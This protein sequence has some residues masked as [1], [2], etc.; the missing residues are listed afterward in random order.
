MN[1]CVIVKSQPSCAKPLDH[2]IIFYAFLGLWV[3]VLTQLLPFLRRDSSVLAWIQTSEDWA[4]AIA[5]SSLL[6]IWWH[7]DNHEIAKS[8][9]AESEQLQLLEREQLAR[10]TSVAALEALRQSEERFRQ[11]AENINQVFWMTTPDMTQKL[12]VSPAYE[13]IWGKSCTS[14][15]EQPSSWMD[16]I[17]PEDRERVLTTIKTQ[18]CAEIDQEFRI[19]H[20]DGSVR[21]IRDRAFPVRDELG[22]VYRI[23]GIGED[24]TDR[25]QVEEEVCK[26]LEKE[27]ELSIL[28]TRFVSMTSHEFRTPLTTIALSSGLL[29][30]YGAKWTQEKKQTHLKRIKSA[31][32]RMAEMLDD[33]LL[34]GKA[35]ADKV[36]FKPAPLE[37]HEFCQEIM[38]EMQLATDK[39]HILSFVSHG[40][41]LGSDT[42]ELP[43]L[44]EKLLHH[45]LTNLLSNA[46]KY[47]PKGGTI[48]CELTCDSKEAIF[49]I[50][51]QG[52]GISKEDQK[53]LFET[54]YRGANVGNIPG[55]GLGLAIVKNF[56]ELHGGELMVDSQVDVGT[57]FIVKLPLRN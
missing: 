14:L 11:L 17:H 50:Q 9:Q 24:I 51:D 7:W 27:R 32:Q 46:I 52:I 3:L 41:C 29:E 15:Y 18:H 54:F 43:L 20:P 4:F 44:D 21:W 38:A 23:V 19:V 16:I 25:K 56:V 5:T 13:K 22:Q 2:N 6:Y 45:I 40:R 57:T 26:A 28:K 49:R 55:T 34:I 30:T 12:Y 39:Q 48:R 42:G 33:V 53:R 10:S 1:R 36:E 37:L 47:S 31:V 35:E 8:K